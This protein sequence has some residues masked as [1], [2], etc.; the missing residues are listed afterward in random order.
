[1]TAADNYHGRCRMA[2]VVVVGCQEWADEVRRLMS[3]PRI[4]SRDAMQ[5][6]LERVASLRSDPVFS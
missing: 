5:G 4:L 3:D 2:V 1:V 6:R